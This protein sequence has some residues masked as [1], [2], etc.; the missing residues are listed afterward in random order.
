VLISLM[1][2]KCRDRG[3]VLPIRGENV[4]RPVLCS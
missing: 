1:F 3:T 2:S 4:T